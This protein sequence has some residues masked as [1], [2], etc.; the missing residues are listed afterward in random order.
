LQT[1]LS[2]FQQP[3]P[4]AAEPRAEPRAE[5]VVAT[6]LPM[7]GVLVFDVETTGTDR[8]RDQVI[9]L[10][11]QYGLEPGVNR[12]WRFRPSVSMSPGA[13][14]VHGISIE[15][16]EDC[17]PFAACADEILQVF[18]EAR[19]IIGY[20]IAFDIDMLQAEY[21][22][23]ARPPMEFAGKQIVD[24]FRLWQQCEPRSLQHAHLR[25]VGDSFAAAHSASADVA[26]TGRV[27]QGMMEKFGLAG[28]D[29]QD[30]AKACD[31][32]GRLMPNRSSWVGPSKH[33]QWNDEGHIVMTFGKHTGISLHKVASDHGDYLRWVIE[34]DFPSHVIEIC[35]RAA[36]LSRARDG[37]AELVAWARQRYGQAAPTETP[38]YASSA[39]AS[40]SAGG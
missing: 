24:A 22:R 8:R 10:C 21:E 14:A 12:V 1:E 38:A 7:D 16:L 18:A 20:N 17:P 27:L 25:F 30:L 37:E 36:E 9:E 23:L 13:Q 31:P 15:D 3:E 2:F 6:A 35:R 32:E 4:R 11:V 29:W 26:A 33:L 39:A 19:V 34:K 28:R 5:P 40:A